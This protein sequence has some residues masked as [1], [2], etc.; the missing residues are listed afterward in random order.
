MRYKETKGHLPFMKAKKY[1]PEDE[2][3]SVDSLS[4][5][6]SDEKKHSEKTVVPA[7]RTLSE[8]A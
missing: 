6:T 3:L 1:A 7:A 4:G 8:S 2:T 5:R